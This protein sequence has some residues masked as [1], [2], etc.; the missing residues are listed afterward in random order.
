MRIYRAHDGRT[1]EVKQA[2]SQFNGIDDLLDSISLATGI[3]SDGII[4]MSADGVQLTPEL[5]TTLTSEPSDVS[6]DSIE[7]FVFN[8]DYLYADVEAVA[9][10]LSETPAL[11]PPISN[12]EIAH[13]PTPKSLEAIVTWSR[14]TLER[15]QDHAAT[16]RQHHAALSTMQRST[17]VALYNLLS[18]SDSVTSEGLVVRQASSSEL[19]RMESLLQGYQRELEVLSLVSIHP[20]LS[21]ANGAATAAATANGSSAAAAGS[22]ANTAS[23]A[24]TSKR[25]LGDFVSRVKMGAVAEACNRVYLELKS[26]LEEIQ[27]HASQLETDTADLRSEVDGADVSPSTETL[28]QATQALDRA[29]K[30]VAFLVETCSPDVHGWP[31]ADK[32][33]EQAMDRVASATSELFELDGVVEVGMSRLTADKNDMMA[34]SLAL[35][36]D[37]SSLQSDFADLSASLTAFGGELHS[38]RVDG[39]RHLARLSNMLWAYG[40]TII[41]AV[42]RREFSKHFLSKSHA[43]AELMARVSA[44]EKKRRLRYHGEVAGQLPWEVK[45]MDESPPSLEI[46]TTKAR[47]ATPELERRDIDTL[48][49]L[50]EEIEKT[51]RQ[52]DEISGDSASAH[53]LIQVKETLRQL[54]ARLDEMDDEFAALVEDN[55]LGGDDADDADDD[56]D[57][58]QREDGSQTSSIV[59][60]RRRSRKAAQS[61]LA[62]ANSSKTL[63]GNERRE[64]ERL[65]KEVQDLLSQMDAREKQDLERHQSEIATLRAECSA[66]RAESRQHRERLEKDAVDVASLRANLETTRA[67]IQTERERRLNMQEELASLRKEALASRK[68]EEEAKRE[69]AEEAERFAELEL[70]LHD[71]QAELEAAKAA[72]RDASDRI[73]GL[74]SEGSNVEKELSAAQ[75]RIEDLS[76]QLEAARKETREARDAHFEAEAAREKAS[77]SYRAEADSDRAIL[78]ENLRTLTAEL[79]TTQ[80]QLTAVN[81][82]A[83]VNNEAVDTLRSQLKGAD[84]AHEDLVKTMEAAKDSCADAEFAKRHAEREREQLHDAVRPLLENLIDLYNHLQSLPALSSSRSASVTAATPGVN[85]EKRLSAGNVAAEPDV[86]ETLEA[87][88]QAALEVFNSGASKADVEVTLAALRAF[89]SHDKCSDVKKRLDMLVTLVRKWQK[90]YKRHAHDATNKLASAVRDRIAFRNFQVGDLALFLPSRNN[91][92][93]P[94][95]WAAFNISCPH[96]FLNA[97]AGSA[98]A[99]QLRSKEWIV[100]RIVRIAE[101]VTNPQQAGGNPFQ[102]PEGVRFSLLDVEGWTPPNGTD[103][104][105]AKSRQVST[106]SVQ[107]TPASPSKAALPGAETSKVSLVDEDSPS[108]PAGQSTAIQG[109][110]TNAA[111]SSSNGE[112]PQIPGAYSQG[113]DTSMSAPYPTTP[114]RPEASTSL[115]GL[116]QKVGTPTNPADPIDTVPSALTRAMRAAG[117]RSPSLPRTSEGPPP[118]PRV[119]ASADN[120]QN[121][122]NRDGDEPPRGS[123]S[124]LSSNADLNVSSIV[125]AFGV[126]TRRR[127]LRPGGVTMSAATSPAKSSRAQDLSYEAMG[128]PFSASP[129]GFAASAGRPVSGLQ[130]PL[131]AR[132]ALERVPSPK[133]TVP[134]KIE[135]NGVSATRS[136]SMVSAHTVTREIAPRSPGPSASVP[137]EPSASLALAR[138]ETTSSHRGSDDQSSV[139]A[140][141]GSGFSARLVPT[142]MQPVGAKNARD[143]MARGWSG[144]SLSPPSANGPHPSFLSRTFGR[145]MSARQ[146]ARSV[147]SSSAGTEGEDSASNG[148]TQGSSSV[149]PSASQILKKLNDLQQR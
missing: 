21:T 132:A 121:L 2:L 84:E 122:A 55:L 45:G 80:Q 15:I 10:E 139:S 137:I 75:E 136:P 60:A 40:A 56:E 43:L 127:N 32:L 67:D 11:A 39:F 8:R 16:S 29:E 133:E 135:A 85:D 106:A 28:Q 143:P 31:V 26:R 19:G 53:H 95:P 79:A 81:E 46:S 4:C 138:G 36:S 64:K 86:D 70:H 22:H 83:K 117:S 63:L 145:R 42:R 102:L 34:R 112:V 115:A 114:V 118:A 65:Q 113:Q 77:R 142:A 103:G 59:L 68:Q 149:A 78:E 5:L 105:P 148:V 82:G 87:A 147:F 116:T 51:L 111:D 6:S 120:S 12:I 57:D 141:S 125:P 100:A 90:T 89:S 109:D 62:A 130:S 35:L 9:N 124:H 18:H 50:I 76:C 52:A 38:N 69:A 98:L 91:V 119:I 14:Q 146:P 101:H 88:H 94:K 73:E 7:F 61:A 129:G 30:L 134:T 20:R 144:T 54:A 92:L 93:D 96:F 13:P 97:P 33:D 104:R 99:A 1:I 131:A 37:I 41:E 140:G 107:N 47:G 126:R 128:N 25:T 58:E 123:R 110:D 108:R 71:V 72:R 66:A 27:C 44:R 3:A 17:S 74:L 49:S 24:G 48:I 23:N